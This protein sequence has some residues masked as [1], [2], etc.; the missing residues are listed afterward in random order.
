MQA[1]PEKILFREYSCVSKIIQQK[2]ET[3]VLYKKKIFVTDKTCLVFRTG[4]A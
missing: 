2:L 3:Q 1:S 4:F